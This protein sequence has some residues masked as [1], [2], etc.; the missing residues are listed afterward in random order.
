MRLRHVVALILLVSSFSALMAQEKGQQERRYAA[1]VASI[2]S[3]LRD[4]GAYS[5][6]R[7]PTL[8][9][10]VADDVKLANYEHPYYEFKIDT[11]PQ[12][13]ETLVRVKASVSAWYTADGATQGYYHQ[14]PSNG[15]L[16]AD[17]L[18][19]L[20]AYLTDH[21]V[22]ASTDIA[23]LEQHIASIQQERAAAEQ[24]LAE[25]KKKSEM[26]RAITAQDPNTR[27]VSPS[28]AK[29]AVY[30]QPAENSSVI[31]KAEPEDE[32]EVLEQRDTWYRVKIGGSEAG[33]VRRAQFRAAT[34]TTP[35][36][37]SAAES[38]AKNAFTIT[39]EHMYPFAGDWPRLKDKTA[40][41]LFVQPST[42]GAANSPP[43]LK[44]QFLE[45]VFANRFGEMTHSSSSKSFDGIVVIFLDSNGG[46]AAATVPDIKLWREGKL[47]KAAFL[48][49]CSLDP[50]TAFLPNPPRASS[51]KN[52]NGRKF[53]K[54][55]TAS[56]GIKETSLSTPSRQ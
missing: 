42:R 20:K 23:L 38:A 16:E 2:K 33:W 6:G 27:L 53:L 37:E 32:F 22:T 9:G 35:G 34:A 45:T 28:Q 12:G 24:R 50:R 8:T 39:R 15:R 48:A 54:P 1:S 56:G 30:S 55:P 29:V 41:F 40:L 11:V 47:S 4:L 26:L 52:T 25:L 46:V 5:G 51:P 43:D 21:L 31:L 10:F 14:L 18:D 7:L 13:D 44:L 36:A 49:K 19:R 3:A 17:L